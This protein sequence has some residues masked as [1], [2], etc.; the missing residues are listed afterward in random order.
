MSERQAG[1]DAALAQANRELALVNQQTLDARNALALLQR[2]LLT[3]QEQLEQNQQAERLLE[4][5][6]HLITA[7]LLAQTEAELATREL[8]E[9][10]QTAKCDALTGLPNRTLF[11]ERIVAA[12]AGAKRRSEGLALLFLDL[13]EFKRIND[14]LGHSVGDEALIETAMCLTSAVRE[15][16]TVARYGG[17][18]FLVLLSDVAQRSDALLVAEKIIAALAAPRI[19]GKNVLRLTGS[20]GISLYPEDGEDP[21]TL[22]D[23]ADAAM[24]RAKGHNIGVAAPVVPGGGRDGNQHDL[25]RPQ[26]LLSHYDNALAEHERQGRQQREANEQL[27]LAVLNAHQLQASAEHAHRQQKN[28]LAMVAHELRNPLTPLAMTAGLL[29]RVKAEEL[30]RMQQIIERQV[31]HISRLIDDLLDVSRANTGKLRLDPTLMDMADTLNEA[32][33]AIL[34]HIEKRQQR[35]D[36]IMPAR[37]YWLNG[38]A[39]RLTQVLSNL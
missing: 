16:D 5:N 24:Y 4:A 38:D 11:G 6:G 29:I 18:E 13:N 15:V 30:P 27:V 17:D 3:T 7:A 22:I 9:L 21:Q 36:F 35:F 1:N 19:I 25:A 33:E 20:I 31:A 28:L 12:I 26:V 2:T 39:V 10:A 8:I 34:P 23:C 37:A 14:T 32:A